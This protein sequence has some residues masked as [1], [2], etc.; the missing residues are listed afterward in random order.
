MKG[1][2]SMNTMKRRTPP[3]WVL[4]IETRLRRLGISK[5]KIAKMLNLNYSLTCNA[6]T[7]YIDR[8]EVVER[9][10]AKIEELEKLEGAE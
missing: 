1:I 5:H 3:E 2:F 6:S 4:D 10:L 8:P 7:G 9:I